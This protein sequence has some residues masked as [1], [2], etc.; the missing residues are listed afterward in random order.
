MPDIWFVHWPHLLPAETYESL[1]NFPVGG[2]DPF[3]K[4]NPEGGFFLGH[5]LYFIQVFLHHSKPFNFL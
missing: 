4:L 5:G 1:S 3:A 2:S